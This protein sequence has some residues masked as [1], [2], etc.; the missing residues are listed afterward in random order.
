VS[1]AVATDKVVVLDRD[2][3]LVID[4]GYLDDPAGLQFTPGAGEAL[5]WWHTHGYRLV[6]I[7]N[8]SG[9]GRGFFPVERVEAMNAR[10][11]AMVM[12]LG[13][14]LEHIYYCPHRPEAGCIC[15]KPA[16]GLMTQAAAD[17]GF[18]PQRAVVIG[19]RESDMEFGRRAGARTIL[20]AADPAPEPP[21]P[22]PSAA[23]PAAPA[24]APGSIPAL[25]ITP[26][27]VLPTLLSAARAVTARG[28]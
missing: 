3:T 28:W 2:G 17:L 14:R 20:I 23:P 24:P 15:R 1:D 4:R 7:T 18:N 6:V 12:E 5:I 19:D 27:L 13:V 22:A 8:Q 9:V 25:R 11:Y 16:L 10:L 21:P 26:D